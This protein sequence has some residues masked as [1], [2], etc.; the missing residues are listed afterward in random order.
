MS[1]SQ[2]KV[3]KWKSECNATERRQFFAQCSRSGG[4][5]VVGLKKNNTRSEGLRS[6][7]GGGSNWL[8]V[9]EEF[10]AYAKISVPCTSS[11]KLDLFEVVKNGRLIHSFFISS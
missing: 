1:D 3:S 4:Q 7:Y 2:S 8:R 9:L 10:E 11:L 5:L 6:Q